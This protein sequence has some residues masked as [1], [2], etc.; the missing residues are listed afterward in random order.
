MNKKHAI[1]DLAHRLYTIQ[2]G[3]VSAMATL[4]NAIA[5]FCYEQTP[6]NG[7]DFLSYR[8]DKTGF[9]FIADKKAKIFEHINLGTDQRL[10]LI[11]NE[12]KEIID[13]LAN[14]YETDIIGEIQ[15]IKIM[16]E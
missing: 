10:R 2:N 5:C 12:T 9:E 13:Y 8:F 11:Y 14:K 7:C 1:N 16:D 3:D 15:E 6:S 4:L